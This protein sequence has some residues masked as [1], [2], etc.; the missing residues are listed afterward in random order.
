MEYRPTAELA[1]AE[2]KHLP[3]LV[4][5][6]DAVIQGHSGTKGE[7]TEAEDGFLGCMEVA[8]HVSIGLS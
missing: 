7:G 4:L 5:M 2:V 3:V 6:A 1:M 8:F